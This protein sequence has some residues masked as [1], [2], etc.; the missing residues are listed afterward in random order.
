MALYVADI[1]VALIPTIGGAL[2]LI[3]MVIEKES[4]LERLR[5]KTWEEMLQL[6]EVSHIEDTQN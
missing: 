3:S 1:K 2:L 5:R 6:P 4:D